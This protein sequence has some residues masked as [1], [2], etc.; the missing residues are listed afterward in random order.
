MTHYGAFLHL[1]FPLWLADHD[2]ST[3][4]FTQGRLFPLQ[5]SRF[6]QSSYYI[7]VF[8]DSTL[9]AFALPTDRVHAVMLDVETFESY[10][11][12]QI[13]SREG[14]AL[15]LFSP[16]W[17]DRYRALVLF[18][19]TASWEISPQLVSQSTLI[20]IPPANQYRLRGRA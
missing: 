4:I 1:N 6:Y 18:A 19:E 15:L 9:G 12:G 14:G 13:G 20:F 17:S 16:P 7:V 11:F 3:L 8:F 10:D 5:I 2:L